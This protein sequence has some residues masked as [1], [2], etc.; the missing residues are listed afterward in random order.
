[1]SDSNPK[2]ERFNECRNTFVTSLNSISILSSLV[3]LTIFVPYTTYVGNLLAKRVEIKKEIKIVNGQKE[4]I[5]ME[6][7]LPNFQE[8]KKKKTLSLYQYHFLKPLS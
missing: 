1:M 4:K 2:L 3:F 7:L 5:P 8:K 6:R